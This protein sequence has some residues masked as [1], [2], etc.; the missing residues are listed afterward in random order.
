VEKNRTHE[1]RTRL[2]GGG[3]VTLKRVGRKRTDDVPWSRYNWWKD[4]DF[5]WTKGGEKEYCETLRKI[6]LRK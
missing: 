2:H 4:I 1:C 6:R 3:D 5:F